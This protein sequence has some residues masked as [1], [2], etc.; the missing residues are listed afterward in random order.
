M[1]IASFHIEIDEPPLRSF[2]SLG[3]KRFVLPDARPAKQRLFVDVARARDSDVDDEWCRLQT[4]SHYR[5]AVQQRDIGPYAIEDLLLSQPLD[6]L[7]E[8]LAR[9]RLAG[10]QR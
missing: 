5:G 7:L 2:A 10:S 4:E 8:L 9:E 6:A 1:R 3:R